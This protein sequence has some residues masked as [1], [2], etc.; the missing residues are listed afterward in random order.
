MW[1]AQGFQGEKE[2]QGRR[3]GGEG[4]KKSWRRGMWKEV[5]ESVLYPTVTQ[6][7]QNYHVETCA[8]SQV[9]EKIVPIAH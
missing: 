3:G 9:L 4:M 8:L 6:E 2:R 1:G 7:V 5:A